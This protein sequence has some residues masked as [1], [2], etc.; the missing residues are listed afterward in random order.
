MTLQVMNANMFFDKFSGG[1]GVWALHKP[2][3]ASNAIGA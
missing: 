1:V 2:D 3:K